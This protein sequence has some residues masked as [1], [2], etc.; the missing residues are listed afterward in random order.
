MA[1]FCYLCFAFVML[2]CM[3]IVALWS[4]AGKGLTPLLSCVRCFIVCC[5]FPVWC[6]GSGVG[7]DCIYS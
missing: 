3:F 6:P 2:S 5:H 4:P 7:L 1:H